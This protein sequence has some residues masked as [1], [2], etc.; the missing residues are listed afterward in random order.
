M[1]VARQKQLH[2]EC[3][4]HEPSSAVH[5]PKHYNYVQLFLS[6]YPNKFISPDPR[7]IAIMTVH[8]HY[9]M[10]QNLEAWYILEGCLLFYVQ[11]QL[12]NA[13]HFKAIVWFCHTFTLLPDVYVY[14][15]SNKSWNNINNWIWN[16]PNRTSWYVTNSVV[17]NLLC[18]LWTAD[19]DE[20]AGSTDMCHHNATCNNNE[21]SYT[22]SCNTGYTG[23]GLSCTSRCV[24][25]FKSKHV[26]ILLNMY[27]LQLYN[28]YIIL[29]L[30]TNFQ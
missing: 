28:I 15:A 4:A 26:T 16:V 23:S 6:C 13:K 1:Y 20:C 2:I 22:C 19:V 7:N 3:F 8:L 21:G 10:R 27:Y 29:F 18:I 24:Y 11:G 5:E 14:T 17:T 30:L 12:L 25:I 9:C